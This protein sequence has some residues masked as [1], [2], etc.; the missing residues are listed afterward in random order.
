MGLSSETSAWSCSMLGEQMSLLIAE[1]VSRQR[2]GGQSV[3]E[4]AC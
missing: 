4:G 1:L 3:H 2:G